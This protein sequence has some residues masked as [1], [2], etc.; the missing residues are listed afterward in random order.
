MAGQDTVKT[1]I[2]VQSDTRYVTAYTLHRCIFPNTK[3]TIV[4]TPGFGDTRGIDEDAKIVQ[5]IRQFFQIGGESGLDHLNAIAIVVKASANKLTK[6][7]KY[8]FNSILDVFGKNTA[9]NFYI[10]FTFDDFVEKPIAI[11]TLEKCE[12]SYTKYFQFNNVALFKQNRTSTRDAKLKRELQYW[13]LTQQNYAECF[14]R[15]LHADSVSLSQSVE[16]LEERD[17]LWNKLT[18][19]RTQMK[20]FADKAAELAKYQ[21]VLQEISTLKIGAEP[22]LNLQVQSPHPIQTD[23]GA[24]T[25]AANCKICQSTCHYP[26][27]RADNE[28]HKC[29]V[30]GGKW[31]VITG[32]FKQKGAILCKVCGCAATEHTSVTYRVEYQL[33]QQKVTFEYLRRICDR[34]TGEAANCEEMIKALQLDIDECHNAM[35]ATLEEAKASM[36]RLDK[37]AVRSSDPT[38]LVEYIDLIV[39]DEEREMKKNY[40]ERINQLK[41]VR[42]KALLIHALNVD[43]S[44]GSETSETLSERQASVAK[45]WKLINNHAKLSARIENRNGETAAFYD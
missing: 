21:A 35:L 45:T 18:K 19:M 20:I 4:D 14:E 22:E 33:K 32:I 10:M 36:R 29:T 43:S 24:G 34:L 7:Q 39:K 41:I 31:G 13:E 30:I 1:N 40:A 17:N 38:T 15:V 26:C 12:I 16:V 25:R 42:E 28:I 27:T 5:Q 2:E 9:K 11:T 44:L 6:S 37:I 3:V 8:V 23:F